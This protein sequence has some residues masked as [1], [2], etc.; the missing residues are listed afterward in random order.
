MVPVLICESG[1][2]LLLQSDSFYKEREY[3]TL[4]IS[5]KEL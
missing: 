1:N 5:F 3:Y 4:K 2:A